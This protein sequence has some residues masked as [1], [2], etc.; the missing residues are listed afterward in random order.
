MGAMRHDRSLSFP[1]IGEYRWAMTANAFAEGKARC[2]ETG[3]ND[4]LTNPFNP[5]VLFATLLEWLE[6]SHL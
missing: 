3:M 1:F 4:F 2:P 6:K 5:A